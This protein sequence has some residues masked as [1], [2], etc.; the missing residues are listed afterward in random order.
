MKGKHGPLRRSISGTAI[1]ARTV[2]AIIALGAPKAFAEGYAELCPDYRQD[3]ADGMQM[4]PDDF[5]EQ[6]ARHVIELLRTKPE[7]GLTKDESE[8]PVDA[9][10][11][12]L[13][14]YILRTEWQQATLQKNPAPEIERRRKEFCDFLENEGYYID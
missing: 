9:W 12:M 5:S 1:A 14:G 8:Q 13:Q 10:L 3:R 6:A 2:V 4:Q 11:A 7:K